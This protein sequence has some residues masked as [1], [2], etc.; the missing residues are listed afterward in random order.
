M[1]AK[2]NIIIYGSPIIQIQAPKF[3]EQ[4]PLWKLR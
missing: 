1:D 4:L 2:R 3:W